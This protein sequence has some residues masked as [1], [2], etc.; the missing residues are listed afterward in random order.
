STAYYLSAS[1]L[2]SGKDLFDAEQLDLEDEGRVWRNIPAG[3]AGTVGQ[4]GRADELGLAAD[5]HQ[6]Y[7]FGPAGDHPCEWETDRLVA[8]VRAV[9]LLTVGQ[10][11]AIIYFDGAGGSR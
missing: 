7:P 3:A 8:L 4:F 9:E 6:L 1:A 11:A 5:L 10:R 2:F